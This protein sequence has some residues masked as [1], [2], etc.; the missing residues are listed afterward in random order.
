MASSG[1]KE[2]AH[3][4][5]L[6]YLLVLVLIFFIFALN[7]AVP[8]LQKEPSMF[9]LMVPVFIAALYLGSGPAIFSA[10]LSVLAVSYF[11]LITGQLVSSFSNVIIIDLVLYIL[12]AF[13]VIYLTRKQSRNEA[14]LEELN[15][16]LGTT[17]IHKDSV[18]KKESS[19]RLIN[20]KNFRNAF[21]HAPIG[22]ALVDLKGF[23]IQMNQSLAEM[24]AYVELEL[25]SKK[26][27]TFIHPD[28]LDRY[29]KN[30][31]KLIQGDTEMNQIEVR[32]ITKTK[33][34]IW[35]QITASVVKDQVEKPLYVI[36]QIYDV[37]TRILSLRRLNAI[38]IELER[39]N[40]EL[41]DFAY[42]ASHDLQEPLRK[43][44][45]F[46]SLLVQTYARNLPEQAVEYLDV[47]N[48]SSVRLSTLINDLL[49]YSRVSAQAQPFQKVNLNALIHDILKDMETSVSENNAVI[50]VA[51]LCEVDGDPMQLRLLFQ[52][53][54]SNSLKYR[55]AETKPVIEITSINNHNNCRIHIKDNGI[56]FNEKYLDKIFTIFQRLHHRRK[57][58]GTGIGLAICKK[59]VDRHHGTITAR[60]REGEG[61][62]FIITLPIK[63]VIM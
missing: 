60:S 29:N 48:T 24:T 37:T 17:L 32:C 20:E 5:V 11:W 46:S 52:N 36:V 62:T 61:S 44:S 30:F 38:N 58:E 59:I 9:F 54:L 6:K 28:E 47:I 31:E 8:L 22:M 7:N 13:L 4:I 15:Q 23:I 3:K 10:I 18:I 12:Q 57:Y 42:V 55:K 56:G 51:P 41:Q 1:I 27:S 33:K 40:T 53:I 25:V 49:T 16:E 43:I 39:S 50:D 2:P 19:Q 26:V 35:V 14:R 34:E 45:S 21:E 63:Q